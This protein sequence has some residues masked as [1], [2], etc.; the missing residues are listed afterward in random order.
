M[1]TAASLF[2][3]PD[4][5]F[6]ELSCPPGDPDWGEDNQVART[7]VALPGAPVWQSHDGAERR[8]FNQNDVVFHYPGS[9]YRRE[10]FRGGG[11]RCLFLIPSGSLIREVAAEIDPAAADGP[12]VRLPPGAPLDGRTFAIS[13]LAARHLA[14]GTGRAGAAAPADPSRARELLYELLRRTIRAAGRGEPGRPGAGAFHRSVHSGATLRARREIVEEAKEFL[15]ARMAERISLD[16]LARRVYVSPYHLA[17][18]FRAATGFSVHGYLVDLRLRNG[19]DRIGA[20]GGHADGIGE[21]GVR[22]GFNSHSHFTASFRRAFGLA[23]S[24]LEAFGPGPSRLEA[25]GL[26]SSHLEA[27]APAN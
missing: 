11:Y 26:G 21:V 22:L 4:L 5:L 27:L 7:I 12:V 25:V 10:P 18:L 14:S 2:E 16:D 17:R 1:A 15:T 13:R 19:L 3:G 9:E 8:L 23:P 20:T 6:A 24:R